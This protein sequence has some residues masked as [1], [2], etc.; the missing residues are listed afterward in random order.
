MGQYFYITFIFDFLNS[1]Y[2]GD[3]LWDKY[4]NKIYLFNMLFG[5]FF[6]TISMKYNQSFK[7]ILSPETQPGLSNFLKRFLH[8]NFM[9][10][11]KFVLKFY[12]NRSI[13]FGL[14]NSV[15]ATENQNRKNYDFLFG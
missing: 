5:D 8:F 10:F 15:I 2:R 6:Y 14:M 1:S 9:I 13:I 7:N 12:S 4:V 11:I 3:K